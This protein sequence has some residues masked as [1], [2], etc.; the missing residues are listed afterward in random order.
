[1]VSEPRPPPLPR[2][3]N[4][5][6][7]FI[8]S[9]TGSIV[10]IALVRSAPELVSPS[11]VP[12][13][14]GPRCRPP[15]M[16]AVASPCS[17]GNGPYLAMSVHSCQSESLDTNAFPASPFLQDPSARGGH[18][19]IPC[20]VVFDPVAKPIPHAGCADVDGIPTTR[21]V[22]RHQNRAVCH[23]LAVP[24]RKA[25]KFRAALPSTWRP[26]AILATVL[27]LESRNRQNGPGNDPCTA[28]AHPFRQ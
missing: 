8:F 27:F 16:F 22:F 20:S 11:S 3:K 25:L 13:A 2:S 23:F 19:G 6:P 21:P 10:P 17:V 9:S 4:L 12:F 14:A 5:L 24:C 7:L 15:S 28:G 18:V 1:M 26:G